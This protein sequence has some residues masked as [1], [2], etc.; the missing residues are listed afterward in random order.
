MFLD[1]LYKIPSE[2]VRLALC[3]HHILI[4]PNF[5]PSREPERRINNVMRDFVTLPQIT[6]TL[7]IQN[8]P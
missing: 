6:T 3:T 7:L 4:D 1:T 2:L 5:T 8:P